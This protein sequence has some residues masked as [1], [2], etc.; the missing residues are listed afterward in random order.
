MNL[1]FHEVVHEGT[2]VAPKS[3]LKH[4]AITGKPEQ[5]REQAAGNVQKH[6]SS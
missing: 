4:D 5:N 6:L 2:M 1:C 3:Q